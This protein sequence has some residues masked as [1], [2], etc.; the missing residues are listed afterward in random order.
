MTGTDDAVKVIAAVRED[1]P[2]LDALLATPASR[3]VVHRP[4]PDEPAE[5]P[6][7]VK[8]VVAAWFDEEPDAST[9][10]SWAPGGHVDA[11]LVDE[12]VQIDAGIDAAD[13]ESSP[14]LCRLVFV[15]RN[16]DLTHE[17][18]AECHFERRAWVFAW[19]GRSM[20]WAYG[21]VEPRLVDETAPW[22]YAPGDVSKGLI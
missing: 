1:E 21:E 17:E 9:I 10:T 5:Q 14:G 20:M 19:F 16:P 6:S 4:H 2:D 18:M 12:H 15:R 7:K 22:R 8:A 11:Y 13:G 3:I